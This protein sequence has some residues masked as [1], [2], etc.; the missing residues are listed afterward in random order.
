MLIFTPFILVRVLIVNQINVVKL[1]ETHGGPLHYLGNRF[2]TLPNKSGHMH[3]DNSW[4]NELFSIIK[5]NNHGKKYRKAVEP[6]A[7]SA[8]WSL[9]AMEVGLADEYII[10][11]SNRILINTLRLIKEKPQ[12]IKQTYALLMQ[13]YDDAESKKDFFLGTIEHYNQTQDDEEKSLLLPFIINHSWSGII[14]YDADCNILYREGP[15]FEGEKAPRYL[16]T[17]SLS[18][19]MVLEE[20]DRISILLNA[21]KVVFKSGDF[22]QVV[23]DIQSGDFIALNPPYPENERSI[24]EKTSMYTELYAPEKLHENIVNLIQRIEMDGIHYYL[25]YGFYNPKMSKFVLLDEAK[26]PRNYFRVLGYEHCA[27]GI[28]LDQMY[29][30]SKFQIPGDFNAQIIKAVD[31]LKGKKLIQ[32]EALINFNRVSAINKY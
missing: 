13:Q 3:A 11:D 1:A 25:T 10:N 20:V 4:L 22:L 18:V 21:N 7:G 27:F 32:Q 14:F 29:F 26:N 8:S 17:A 5:H 19:S 28:G 31:V 9:A 23:A 6:F 24:T 15:L 30:S 12:L 16:E 2:L